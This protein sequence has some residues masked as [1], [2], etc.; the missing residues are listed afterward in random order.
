MRRS[1]TRAMSLAANKRLIIKV[2]VAS[3]F[4]MEVNRP[5]R[6]LFLCVQF[7][8]LRA[9]GVQLSA[10]GRGSWP[11][12]GGGMGASLSAH[13]RRSRPRGL[14][15]PIDLGCPS[16]FRA[17]WARW[18]ILFAAGLCNITSGFQLEWSGR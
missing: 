3:G 1:L 13:K 10:S 11:M 15:F 14:S 16:R 12:Y 17:G 6:L 7:V 18:L 8:A 5:R 2:V 4:Q 9:R